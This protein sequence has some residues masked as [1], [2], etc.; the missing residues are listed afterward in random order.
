MKKRYRFSVF[1]AGV[2]RQQPNGAAPAPDPQATAEPVDHRTVD[3]RRLLPRRYVE[4]EGFEMSAREAL[5]SSMTRRRFSWAMSAL[6]A[7]TRWLRTPIWSII[8]P[9]PTTT[10]A[11]T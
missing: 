6:A 7:W 3:H 4:D 2:K 5:T 1:M 11:R 9:T 10:W 8:L